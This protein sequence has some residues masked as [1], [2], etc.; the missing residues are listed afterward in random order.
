[1][2]NRGPVSPPLTP[3]QRLWLDKYASGALEV[4]K[5]F[6]IPMEVCLGMTILESGWIPSS[7]ASQANN[8]HG[9]KAAPGE[10]FVVKVTEEHIHASGVWS[11]EK[12]LTSRGLRILNKFPLS[13]QE[14]WFHYIIEDKFRKFPSVEEGFL[15][16]GSLLTGKGNFRFRFQ[17]FLK[18]QNIETF[19]KELSQPPVYFS[20]RDYISKWKSIINRSE[21][22]E[23]IKVKRAV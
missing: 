14:G 12:S 2:V 1:M 23:I 3:N 4:E 15:G 19:M 20:D 13:G 18:H 7:L 5:K 22:K 21:V 8:F 11:F 9:I 16:Y 10:E 6:K 17:N